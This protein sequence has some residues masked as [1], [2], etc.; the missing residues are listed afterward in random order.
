MHVELPAVG[1]YDPRAQVEHSEPPSFAWKDRG[2]QGAHPSAPGDGAT[3]PAGHGEHMTLPAIALNLP[4]S[5]A[6]HP[7]ALLSWGAGS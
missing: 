7:S 6:A 2:G 1:A 4:T 5:Q 3:L